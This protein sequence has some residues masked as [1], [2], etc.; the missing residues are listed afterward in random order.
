M[1][2]KEKHS[3]PKWISIEDL[4][5]HL[6]LGDEDVHEWIKRDAPNMSQDHMERPT[7]PLELLKQ[8]SDSADYL[9][10]LPKALFFENLAMGPDDQQS[11][12]KWKKEKLQILKSCYSAIDSL[13]IIHSKCLQLVNACEYGSKTMA[14]YL[15]FSRVISTLKMSCLCQE[16]DYWHWTALLRE[17]NEG[18]CLAEYFITEGDS[19]NG[20]EYLHKWFRQNHAPKDLICRDALATSYAA[21]NSDFTKENHLGLMEEL[22]GKKSKLTH[23]TFRSIREITKFKIVDGKIV[24]EK[25][26]CGPIRYQRK[27]LELAVFFRSNLITCFSAFHACF[28]SLPLNKDDANELSKIVKK[29]FDEDAEAYHKEGGKY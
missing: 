19:P 21:A 29:L 22:Y 2:G 5:Y 7:V 10:A 11:N 26:E 4:S 13:E 3:L 24:I 27:L 8:Y 12:Q 1:S 14:A 20:K 15:L 17:V 18:I 9:K 28:K 25:L 6:G 16:H 23:Q